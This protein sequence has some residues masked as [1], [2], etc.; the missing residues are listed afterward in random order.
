MIRRRVTL[1]HG[2]DAARHR[3]R[4]VWA[5]VSGPHRPGAHPAPVGDSGWGG[6][7]AGFYAKFRRGYPAEFIDVL[8]PALGLGTGDLVLDLGCG[9]GQL[10]LPLA[11]RVRAV[12]GMDPE[13]DMLALARRAA[14]DR[15]A[16]NV[17]WVLGGDADVPGLGAVLG[18]RSLAAVTVGNAIHLMDHREL[19]RSVMPLLRRGGGLAVIANGTPL[20]QQP[21]PWSSALRHGLEQWL[22]TR[23]D[24]CCGTD[25]PSRQHYREALLAEGFTGVHEEAAGYAGQ[26]AFDDLIG[27][28]YS[29]MPQGMLPPPGQRA[30][31]E[32]HLRRSIGPGEPFTEEVRVAALIGHVA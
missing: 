26:L 1:S 14:A 32:E 22:G 12:V 29:A 30:G 27:G 15:G 23:L 6:E 18:G 17:A 2:H 16:G 8:A 28:V 7:V 21:A 24:S 4:R 5:C 10:T 31:F 11:S 9:T 20:W 3:R 19:F 25:A 13:P